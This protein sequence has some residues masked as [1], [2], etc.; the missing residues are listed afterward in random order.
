MK[1]I[2]WDRVGQYAS[3]FFLANILIFA[4]GYSVQGAEKEAKA[5]KPKM[6]CKDGGPCIT[7]LDTN[8]VNPKEA[9]RIRKAL[10][11]ESNKEMAIPQA[12]LAEKPWLVESASLPVNHPALTRPRMIWATSI[13]WEAF[14][15]I[16][17]QIPVEKWI[18]PL[19]ND[20]AGKYILIEAWATWCP[21]C[22]RSLPYLNFIQ[23]KYK[24]ELV[25]VAICEVEEE[26]FKS[27]PGGFD[28]YKANFSLAIDTGRRFANKLNV[29][30]IPHAILIEPVYG[31]VIWEG[32]PTLPG[33][34]LSDKVL[35]KCF[36]IGRK[37]KEDG[38]LPKIS[39]VQFT[40]K[41]ATEEERASRRK[42]PCSYEDVEGENGG[43]SL[44]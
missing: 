21:P 17:P 13:Q 43:P 3:L 16:M 36:S 26:A 37:L 19:P 2:R 29:K 10:G 44:H 40:I 12:D 27:M 6:I 1:F 23:K 4:F 33:Y 32:M 34:E 18:T 24:D 8:A 38:K 35:E 39:P 5:P 22:R 14:P 41:K 20:L 31:G 9:E 15:E 25:V 42:K 30:G 28:P 7:V 11:L